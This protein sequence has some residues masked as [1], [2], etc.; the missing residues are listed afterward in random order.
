MGS[1][2]RHTLQLLLACRWG[3][4]YSFLYH[5]RSLNDGENHQPVAPELGLAWGQM[6]R[7]S[8]LD[9]AASAPRS[10]RRKISLLLPQSVRYQKLQQGLVFTVRKPEIYIRWLTEGRSA[11][12]Y[13]QLVA[14]NRSR[15]FCIYGVEQKST[16]LNVCAVSVMWDPWIQVVPV[17]LSSQSGGKTLFEF[18]L[19][20]RPIRFWQAPS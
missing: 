7:T 8:Q 18:L 16:A 4:L 9:N 20:I 2:A 11:G 12:W 17:A 5:K 6:V 10:S 3:N 1:P 13:E 14:P 15:K 19:L